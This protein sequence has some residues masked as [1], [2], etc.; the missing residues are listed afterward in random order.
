MHDHYISTARRQLAR[1]VIRE[2]P[3]AAL[4]TAKPELARSATECDATA[5]PPARA[6]SGVAGAGT[7]AARLIGRSTLHAHRPRPRARL[8]AWRALARMLPGM[9]VQ[10]RAP[11]AFACRPGAGA[12][13][14]AARLAKCCAAECPQHAAKAGVAGRVV[15]AAVPARERA[16][17]G[18]AF[19]SVRS[20][21]PAAAGVP[22]RERARAAGRPQNANSPPFRRAICLISFVFFARWTNQPKACHRSS[23]LSASA[24]ENAA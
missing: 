9:A 8:R 17:A 23:I 22:A 5:R 10:Q 14:P 3:A 7:T 20:A 18:A 12:A 19:H 4:S 2:W 16:R 24:S 15:A 1:R 11:I 21:H 6:A 13:R